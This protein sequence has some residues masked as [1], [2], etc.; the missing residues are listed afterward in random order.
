MTGDTIVALS[1]PVGEGGIGIVR[2]SGP[3]AIRIS[4][5]CFSCSGETS[6]LEVPSH[7]LHHGHI[8]VRGRRVDEVL[9]SVMRAPRTYTREDVVEINCH[10]GI[11]ACRAVLDAVLA[12]GARLAERGEFTKRAFLSGRISL[13]QAQAV[14]DIVRARTAL[15]LEA[16]VDRLG[17]RFSGA[18]AEVREGIAEVLAGLDVEINFPDLDVTVDDVLPRVRELLQR[19]E[20]LLA[21]GEQGRVVREGLTVAI[22]GRPN[23]GKSTL[24]NA[25]LAEKRAIVTPIPGTTRDTVEEVAAISGVPVRLIDTAGLREPSDEVEA[26]GVRRTRRA[27]DRADLVLLLLDRS[28]PMAVADCRL[29]KM[30]WSVPVVLILTKDDLPQRLENVPTAPWKKTIAISAQE[31]WNVERLREL[32]LK[33][34]LGGEIPSRDTILL[35]DDWERDLLR[36]VRAALTETARAVESTA[37]PDMVAEELRL[38]YRVAGE[39][40]G[41]DVSESILDSIFSGFC[42]GK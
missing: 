13:D 23:V 21:Q 20:D 40:Q 27:I 39:L 22:I 18:I 3:E 31:G 16:A 11:V 42:V 4:D 29:L 5:S 36:R 15:G 10:G 14:L 28:Q 9:V 35:L 6:L 12:S 8:V 2:L 7:T 19:V 38:A 33:L 32:L 24:L 34:L 26:E 37:S 41:I 30:Q 1:T 25:L 17:G